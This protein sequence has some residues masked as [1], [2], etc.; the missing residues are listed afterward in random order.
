MLIPNN[1]G[2]ADD[3]VLARQLSS[4]QVK[5]RGW[6]RERGPT[7]FLDMPMRLRV[8]TGEVENNA[9]TEYRHI[10]PNAYRWGV[11]TIPS[12]D[13]ET[14]AF[15][16]HSGEKPWRSVPGEYRALLLD[17][18]RVQADVENAAIEQSRFLT[19]TAPSHGDLERLFLFYLEEGRHTWA[20]VH[21]LLEHFGHD[22]EVEAEALLHRLS[23]DAEK[24]RLLDAF[25]YQTE[26]WLSH[27]FWCFL[28][29]RVGKYQI[30]AVTACAFAPLAASAKFMMREEPMHI[31]IGTLGL[32]RVLLRS[33][34]TTLRED[35]VDVFESGAVPLPV[36]QKYLNYWAT[37]TYDLF[38]NDNSARSRD[39]YRA[40]LRIPR[41]FDADGADVIVDI[42][43]GDHV[44]QEARRP[45]FAI[46]AIMR[47]QFIGELQSVIGRWNGALERMGLDFRLE[48]PHE[49][50][51]RAFGPCKD[52]PFDV[53]GVPIVVDA[54]ARSAAFVPSATEFAQVQALMRR[55]LG[56]G[57]VAGWI[58]TETERL[59]RRT[60]DAEA[61]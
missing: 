27:F 60:S 13:A 41:N 4:Y 37:K 9:W 28:A 15:G 61:F 29:D 48:V 17:Y 57:R 59:S 53:A 47:R 8:P 5:F 36:F 16:D 31:S 35:R 6:W 56:D 25:N 19:R 32:E 30:Q 49:R 39:L 1:I 42:R 10:A 21:L 43:V 33:A 24:P 40:G 12:D 11:F 20:M 23:G 45:E 26:D 51:N 2:L 34:A 55:E 58:A 3:S 18:I 46:N 22:G 44:E 52:L 50:M 54:E 38:G 14:I 7:E